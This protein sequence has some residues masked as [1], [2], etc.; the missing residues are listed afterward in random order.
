M[1]AGP[2]R[3]EAAGIKGIPQVVCPGAIDMVNFG[4]MDSVPVKYK[5]RLL[6][7]HNPTVTLMRTTPEEN[8]Q[9]G[10]ITAEK[11]NQSKGPVAVFMPLKG[12]SAID[13]PGAP[14]HSPEADRN[15]LD[16]LKAHLNSRVRLVEVDANINDEIFVQQVASSLLD[17]IKARKS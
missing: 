9:L 7:R 3:L 8:S 6:Y 2:H 17:M 5:D 10:K 4:P 14:F 12:V 13:I 15:Y 16:A 11:L 1:S